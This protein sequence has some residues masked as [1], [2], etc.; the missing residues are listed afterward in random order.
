MKTFKTL[1]NE[2]GFV[3]LVVYGVVIFV[4]VFSIVFF[5]RHRTAIQATER[6]QNRILAFNA[7]ESGIDY[8]LRQLATDPT[9]RDQTTTTS[10]T[11]SYMSMEQNQ[12]RF[13]ASPVTGRSDLRRIDSQG[14]APN[15]TTTS[16]GYQTSNITVYCRI[17]A[18]EPP[19]SLFTYGV[20][21]ANS[22]TM[23]GN[24]TFDSYDSR[25]G[26]YGGS[27]KSSTETM[28]VNSTQAGKMNLSGNAKIKGNVLVGYNGVPNTVIA[29][30]GN[31]SITG[32]RSNLDEDWSAYDAP[33]L[34]ET[35]TDRTLSVSGNNTITLAAGTYHVPSISVSGNA[36]ITATGPVVIYVDGAVSIAGNG[37][38]VPNNHPANLLIYSLGSSNVSIA[39]NGSFYGGVF[40][41]NSNVTASGNGGV[42]GAVISKTYTQSGNSATHFDVAM[43]EITGPVDPDQTQIVR[44]KAWQEL[45]SLAWGTG[46]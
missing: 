13:V 17:T 18:D 44:V 11:S 31:A 32:T 1:H 24:A 15:C 4:S 25:Q 33:T 29:T 27:N 8:A 21:S 40:A 23:S 12:F 41:P 38:V 20:Y 30:S 39:G 16:R 42:F 35:Y 37:M 22:I 5:A 3:L 19:P 45:Y 34:P 43:K 26:A 28:A 6:Y 2:R 46:S 14:C 9:M 36:R 7:A 10:Y